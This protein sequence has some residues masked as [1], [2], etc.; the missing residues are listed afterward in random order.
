MRNQRDYDQIIMNA[1]NGDSLS[2][3]E[4]AKLYKAGVFG[5]FH[6]ADSVYWYCRFLDSP[7]IQQIQI[8]I[9]EQYSNNVIEEDDEDE[10]LYNDEIDNYYFLNKEHNCDEGDSFILRNNIINAGMSIGLYYRFSNKKDELIRARDGFVAALDA[11]AWDYI[12]IGEG[13]DV[14]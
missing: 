3:Y 6:D 5:D 14:M 9:E 7:D 2:M 10:S 12:E 11:S 1:E 4:L 13:K 8:Y